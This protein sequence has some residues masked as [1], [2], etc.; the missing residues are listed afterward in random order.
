MEHTTNLQPVFAAIDQICATDRHQILVA[1]DGQ[2]ASGKTTLGEMLQKRYD[3]NLFHMD[4]FFLRPEQRTPER[5]R[6]IGGNVDYERFQAEI[7]QHIDDP[8]GLTYQIFSCSRMEL[9]THIRVPW[10][11]LNIIE[12]AYSQHPWFGDIYDLRFYYAIDEEEQSRRILARNGEAQL[13]RFRSLWIPKENAYLE[14]FHI[15]EQ[16]Q[17]VESL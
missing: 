6:E 12:G 2:S 3:C 15:P 1:I 5:L 7:L 17:K 9:G 16:S 4:D 11:R 14:T 8:D 10:K 13:E